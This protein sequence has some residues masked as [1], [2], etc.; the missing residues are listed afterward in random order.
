MEM[1]SFCTTEHIHPIRANTR[2]GM[3]LRMS[4]WNSTSRL[5]KN[6]TYTAIGF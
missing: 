3:L 1:V 4:Q 5:T 2:E 6:W